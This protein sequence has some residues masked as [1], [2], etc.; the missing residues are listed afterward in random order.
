MNLKVK[1]ADPLIEGITYTEPKP[2]LKDILVNNVKDYVLPSST[3]TEGTDVDVEE[4]RES[5]AILA[6][7]G[8]TKD[9]LGVQMSLGDVKKL[10]PKDVEKYYYRYQSVLSKQV[11]GGLVENAIKLASKIISRVIPIDDP[12]SLSSDLVQD[13]IVR[14][15][16]VNAA[17]YL[18]LKG[19]R[20]VALA[21]ALFH[22]MRHVNFTI[23]DSSLYEKVLVGDPP[24][25]NDEDS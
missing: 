16:L 15:E 7:L 10:S 22:V 19:G 20:F 17:G 24:E 4:K 1:M 12:D 9:Y 6:S 25:N 14:R 21:S 23:N 5:L 18:V 8:T 11:T 2:G 13:E 3:D